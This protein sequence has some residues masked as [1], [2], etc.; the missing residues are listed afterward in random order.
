MGCPEEIEIATSDEETGS[1]FHCFSSCMNPTTLDFVSHC[2]IISIVTSATFFDDFAK[3]FTSVKI[4]P[5][6]TI[7]ATEP[8]ELYFCCDLLSHFHFVTKPNIQR[9]A[10]F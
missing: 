5:N 3:A 10:Q 9:E 2:A 7:R 6:T 1:F 4:R 8:F